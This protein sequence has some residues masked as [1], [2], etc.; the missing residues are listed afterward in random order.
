MEGK[1]SG[2]RQVF[3]LFALYARMD[4]AW[5]LRDTMTAL[6]V[7]AAEL[8]AQ[9]AGV[10]GVFLIAWRFDGI[11]GMDRYEVLLLL[12]FS[13]M[14][15]GLFSLFFNGGNTGHLS[16]RIGRGQLEHMMIQPVPLR[17]QL[18]TDGFLPASGCSGLVAGTLIAAAAVRRLGLPVT[19][20]W[21]L[22]FAGQ[23]IAALAVLL[24]M[25]YLGSSAAF[26]YPSAAEEIATDVYDTAARLSGF[27]LS[28]LSRGVQGVLLTAL[29]AGLIAWFPTLVLLGRP[30]FGLGAWFPFALAA[31]LAVLAGIVMKKG[32]TYYARQGSPRYSDLGHRR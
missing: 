3:A 20:G 13:T 4:F 17:V 25:L 18:L 8:T 5:L 30:P 6:L 16:R 19:P 26:W 10:T 15:Q 24:G 31:L 1:R 7:I 9:V 23:L 12:G 21:L 28:D 2:L 11:G 14:V 27:P 29:P 22:L 32:W